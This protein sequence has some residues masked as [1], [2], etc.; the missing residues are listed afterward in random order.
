MKV[1]KK[2]DVSKYCLYKMKLLNRF[3]KPIELLENYQ[4]KLHNVQGNMNA[5]GSCIFFTNDDF[6]QFWTIWY[7]SFL[8]IL[9]EAEVN[10]SSF[11]L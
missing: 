9:K 2:K 6:M 4:T 10:P 1:F 7:S 8:N 5:Y 3:R 11:S